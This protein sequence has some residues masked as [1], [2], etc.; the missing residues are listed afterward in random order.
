MRVPRTFVGQAEGAKVERHSFQQ[1]IKSVDDAAGTFV[2]MAAVYGNVDLGGDVV[3]PGAFT[4]TL[5]TGKSFPILW[6]HQPDQP[7]GSAKVTETREGLLVNGTL[8]LS[9]PTAQKAHTFLKAGVVKGLSIGYDAIQATYEGD[10]RHLKEL[11]LWEVSVVTFP[12]NPMAMV[13]TV[14]AMS[15]ADRG[16]HLK[17]INIHRKAIDRH[18]RSIRDHLK[19]LS[20]AFDDDP[21]DDLALIND[22]EGDEEMDKSFLMA[23]LKKLAE[24]ASTLAAL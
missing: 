15:D 20:D 7:I 3:D 18:Q 19:S 10:I 12:M 23:E 22:D 24:Q 13:A 4:R 17:Q 21:E 11:R 1:K 9:D 2:G 16:E 8:M 6:Q 14:K 5:G